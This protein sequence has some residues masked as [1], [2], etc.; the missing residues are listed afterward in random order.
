M[1]DA[2]VLRLALN[3]DWVL[4][5]SLFHSNEAYRGLPHAAGRLPLMAARSG[6]AVR[7]L[8]FLGADLHA[9]VN[10]WCALH[11]WVAEEHEEGRI[12]DLLDA[13]REVGGTFSV[14]THQ[15]EDPLA[16]ALRYRNRAAVVWMSSHAAHGS[17]S[18]PHVLGMIR[19]GFYES[20]SRASLYLGNDSLTR[21]GHRAYEYLPPDAP[22]MSPPLD[23]CITRHAI[24][25]G[26]LKL[27]ERGARYPSSVMRVLY[28]LDPYALTVRSAEAIAHV[29]KVANRSWHSVPMRIQIHAPRKIIETIHRCGVLIPKAFTPPTLTF[30]ELGICGVETLR[31]TP[32]PRQHIL[33]VGDA[34]WPYIR[35]N[36]RESKVG[37]DNWDAYGELKAEVLDVVFGI[38][39]LPEAIL[40]EILAYVGGVHSHADLMVT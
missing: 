31:Y 37:A 10:G 36:R 1:S 38:K 29:L 35:D 5:G 23:E 30:W 21:V 3:S 27:A 11:Y 9:R 40:M 13:Y 6:G 16:I 34:T 15:G 20:A 4:A 12:W 25:E 28:A 32:V 19:L 33:A 17:V 7:E 14:K 39:L 8:V 26:H 24:L 22:L 18:A 2:R